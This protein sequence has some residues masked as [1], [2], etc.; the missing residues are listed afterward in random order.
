MVTL[1]I[2]TRWKWTK[3]VMLSIGQK[4][5]IDCH[6][7]NFKCPTSDHFMTMIYCA[8]AE[9]SVQCHFMANFCYIRSELRICCKSFQNGPECLK[10]LM[11]GLSCKWSLTFHYMSCL[12][13]LMATAPPSYYIRAIYSC[14]I[15][16][17]H[18][19]TCQVKVW[20]KGLQVQGSLPISSSAISSIYQSGRGP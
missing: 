15:W 17:T 3:W 16:S 12:S 8:H 14:L 19:G 7:S 6:E 18:S 5:Y 2:C 10:C 1:F 9:K 20:G 13:S 11:I 4:L